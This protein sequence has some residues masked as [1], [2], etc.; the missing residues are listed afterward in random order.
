MFIKINSKNIFYSEGNDSLIEMIKDEY[1]L[2]VNNLI[3]IEFN[4]CLAKTLFFM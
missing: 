1:F 4:E 3:Q 2:N